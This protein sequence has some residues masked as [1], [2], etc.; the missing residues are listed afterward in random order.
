ME[1]ISVAKTTGTEWVVFQ[2]DSNKGGITKNI[3]RSGVLALG[4]TSILKEEGTKALHGSENES[5]SE[6]EPKKL[7]R[8]WK[9]R[10]GGGIGE[11]VKQE[12]LLRFVFFHHLWANLYLITCTQL[13]N[14]INGRRP[15]DDSEDED[16]SDLVHHNLGPQFNPML[17][18]GAGPPGW[19]QWQQGQPSPGLMPPHPN[20]YG[21]DAN[22]L[23]AHQ[24]AMMIAK[25]TYQM[26]VAQQA[27]AAA[28][29]EWERN[30]SV[31]GFGGN[32]GFVPN[33]GFGFGGSNMG[34]FGMGSGMGGYGSGM[35]AG[36]MPNWSS[37]SL[38]APSGPRSAYGGVF[39]GAQ[40]EYGGGPSGNGG[41]GSRSMY[42][43]SFGPSPADRASRAFS[44]APLGQSQHRQ[45]QQTSFP[46]SKG[47][48]ERERRNE[49]SGN[50]NRADGGSSS[51]QHVRP[52]PR[53]RT[54]TAPS[55]SPH[56]VKTRRPQPPASPPPSS[57]R[58]F[59]GT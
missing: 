25:Q 44:A 35:G 7:R 56:Q 5:E 51:G 29:D 1:V 17:A 46:P 18:M 20:Q 24:Q 23:A 6:K 31:S 11:G 10:I 50:S 8:L 42:G 14:V 58:R 37:A 53:L 52:G 9:V 36:M 49:S 38:M 41:W 40:S 47:T 30:S 16:N 15:I 2:V 21:Q 54:L 12:P 39:G 34:M 19:N 45:Q 3:K 33:P 27:L 43:E 57:F 4:K 48:R 13:G 59:N 55:D 22:F 28:G 32:Q 26:A